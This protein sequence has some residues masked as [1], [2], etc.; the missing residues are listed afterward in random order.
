M[1][2]SPTALKAEG[3]ATSATHPVCVG[4]FKFPSRVAQDR[5]EVVK[6]PNYYDA[7]KVHL[8]KVIVQ[9][10]RR[11]DH[12]VQQPALR[13]RAGARR[14]RARPTSTRCK[15][16]S[17]LQLLTSDSLG[18]QGI[19]VNLGN[20][21]GVGK[22]A[23]DAAGQPCQRDGHRPAGAA[24]VR[25]E[26]RPGGHQQGG[27]PGQVQRRPAGRS[28]RPARSARDAAQ[29][30]PKH[31]PAAAKTLLQQAG[32]PTPVKISMIIGNTPG[33][34]P[35]RAGDPGPGQGRR[36]RPQAGADRVR[37][38]A[39][40]DRRRQVPDVPDRLVRPGRPGRQHRQLRHLGG[41]AEQQRLQQLHCGLAA[42]A[43]PAPP[44]T[45][46]PGRPVRPGDHPAAQGPADHLPLPAEELHRRRPHRRG[47]ADVRRRAD[48]VRPR[49]ASPP[50]SAGSDVRVR[51]PAVR[52]GAGWAGISSAGW[53]SRWSRSCW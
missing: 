38:L 52:G 1:I 12:A 47:R 14:G 15:A 37:R 2:M 25:D 35:A 34:R 16:D 6:D 13:R 28:A 49:R 39:R 26:P 36:L 31:D 19:T 5:I 42:R 48:A 21:N 7:A 50:S 40:P 17:N 33:R 27:V 20:V 45:W 4:P 41:I 51:G 22:P 18:Y 29:A 53:P 23:G 3:D 46:P 10:H 11:L 32:V 44:T 9:D 24:G 8:D 30:C 43:E